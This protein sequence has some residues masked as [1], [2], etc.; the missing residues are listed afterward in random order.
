MLKRRLRES[1]LI[2]LITIVLLLLLEGATRLSGFTPAKPL[3]AELM[4]ADPI[5]LWKNKPGSYGTRESRFAPKISYIHNQ[6][7]FRIRNDINVKSPNSFRVL[8]M[9]DSNIWGFGVEQAQTVSE[10][11]QYRYSQLDLENHPIEVLNLGVIGHTSFQGMRWLEQLL[12]YQPDMICFA[13]G[14]NDRR[15]V[16][17]SYSQ[18][19][20]DYFRLTYQNIRLH[21]LLFEWS[22][23]CGWVSSWN[24][25]EKLTPFTDAVPRVPLEQ[26]KSNFQTMLS[27]CDE[28]D[29]PSVVIGLQDN[30]VIDQELEETYQ[31]QQ[32]GKLQD[33]VTRYMD[34]MKEPNITESTLA[35]YYVYGILQRVI[36]S[37]ELQE[38]FLM[39]KVDQLV[40]ELEESFLPLDSMMGNTVIRGDWEYLAIL[41]EVCSNYSNSFYIEYQELINS[42]SIEEQYQCYFP[43]DPCHINAKGHEVLAEHLHPIIWEQYQTFIRGDS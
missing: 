14:Y 39:E 40:S 17:D 24:Q 15:Y 35:P 13:Y 23:M 34:M 42:M 32:E 27:I 9:G 1:F 30:P 25:P 10:V 2:V 36:S 7:G 11:L 6:Q 18:D 21:Q 33:A 20:E 26:Y 22:A 12:I 4:E 38:D 3:L 41:Q 16:A 29:I 31:L 28:H 5:V 19:G 8:M 43:T 37:K